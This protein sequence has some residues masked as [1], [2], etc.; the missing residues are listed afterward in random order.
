MMA[1][2]PK[3]FAPGFTLIELVMVIVILG[4]VAITMLPRFF[5]QDTFRTTA[6]YQDL[7]QGLRYSQQASVTRGCRIRAQIS[8]SGYA[9]T[10]DN[11]CSVATYN[12]GNFTQS[13][14]RP[15]ETASYANTDL[16]AGVITVST[17]LVFN[18]SGSIQR[19]TASTTLATISTLVLNLGSH[20]ITIYGD[21]GLVE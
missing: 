17:T 19:E 8:A 7:L 18:P 15:G 11:S 20:S 9:I 16:P 1:R 10:Q 2:R 4:I 13:L 21:T 12:S 5:N 3:A 6:F 14:R